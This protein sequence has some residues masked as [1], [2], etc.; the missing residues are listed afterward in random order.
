MQ[1]EKGEDANSDPIR[2]FAAER[3]HQDSRT[4]NEYGRAAGQAMLL[5]NGG[6][7]SAVVALANKD[8]ITP[9]LLNAFPL[10]LTGYGLGVLFAAFMIYFMT[11]AL[12]DW[13]VYWLTWIDTSRIEERDK[14][15][16]SARRFWRSANVCFFGAAVA[17][18]FATV[19]V[20][21]AIR[22]EN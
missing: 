11:R 16:F 21:L 14:V 6:A 18:V 22:P 7:G 8:E 20:G 12:D 19:S 15:R 1:Q 17:F 5:L 4:S 9:A 3:S 10:I 13:N 2:K